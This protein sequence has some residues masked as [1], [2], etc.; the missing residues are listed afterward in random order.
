MVAAVGNRVFSEQLVFY[1]DHDLQGAAFARQGGGFYFLALQVVL[2][3]KI[4]G[5]LFVDNPF[6]VNITLLEQG[7]VPQDHLIFYRGGCLRGHIVDC[8]IV[9]MV[10]DLLRLFIFTLVDPVDDP[11]IDH[12]AVG[13]EHHVDS[14]ILAGRG[15]PG[16]AARQLL[17]RRRCGFA[18]KL[19]IAFRCSDEKEEGSPDGQA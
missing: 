3:F 16:C 4:H 11:L 12:L 10:L 6:V 5:Q 19:P 8:L 15:F 1:P 14:F 2:D 7:A 18:I 17:S 9:S 13:I